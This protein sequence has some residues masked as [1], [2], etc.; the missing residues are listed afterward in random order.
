M[1]LIERLIRWYVLEDRSGAKVE[2][3]SYLMM[4]PALAR[5]TQHNINNTDDYL[6]VE[7]Y[8]KFISIKGEK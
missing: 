1:S 3:V 8:E 7:T 5:A 2:N 6:R 4:T